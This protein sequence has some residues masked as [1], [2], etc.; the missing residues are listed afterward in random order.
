VLFSYSNLKAIA[1][2]SCIAIAICLLGL[3]TLQPAFAHH[4]MGGRTPVNFFEGF[5]SGLG[6]PIIELDHFA[7]IVAVGLLAVLRTKLGILIPLAFTIATGCGAIIHLQSIDLPIPE[8]IIALSVLIIGII[9]TLQ[10]SFNLIFLISLS[11]I[12]GIFH[13]F[14]YG[15]AIFG[16]EMTP[17]GAYLLGFVVIQ[18]TI[19]AI[20]FYLG[21]LTIKNVKKNGS[22]ALRFAGCVIAGI[23]ISFLSGALLG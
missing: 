3:V 11:A 9:L 20:A 19:S 14:A 23:G 6:H 18:L 5:L 4:P 21:S 1:L 17:L 2:K 13:G 16:A 12:S 7:F 15:E 22:L 8:V 10:K